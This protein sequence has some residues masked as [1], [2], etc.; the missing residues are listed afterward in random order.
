[1][2][3]ELKELALEILNRG[4]TIA[5]VENCTCGLL[6]ASIGS[7]CAVP[8]IY[9]GT[10]NYFNDN[11]L[12]TFMGIGEDVIEVNG[13]Y[14]SQVA[15]KTALYAS[16]MFNVDVCISVIGDAFIHEDSENGTIWICVC[17][18]IDGRVT[19]KYV[20]IEANSVRSKNIEKAIAVALM[21]AVEHI[22]DNGQ[23]N[24]G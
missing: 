23:Q 10:L 3:K 18:K 16:Y 5:T 24:N 20:K 17:K 7:V 14:S 6:G 21:S 22:R 9:K 19:F 4:L 1:M 8:A 11:A 13:L 15:M 12:K 2:N